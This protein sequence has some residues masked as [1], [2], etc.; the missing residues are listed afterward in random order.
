MIFLGTYIGR[1][2]HFFATTNPLNLL[3]SNADLEDA[4]NVLD[5]YR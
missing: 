2:K 4:K 1:A 5:K 3:C